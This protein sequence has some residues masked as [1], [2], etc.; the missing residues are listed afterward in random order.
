M[1]AF[2][3]E[4]VPAGRIRNMK[5]VF[6]LSKAQNLILEETMADGSISRR[7]KTMVFEIKH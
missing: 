4:G 7:V 3:K 1:N 5:E 6:E 2:Q